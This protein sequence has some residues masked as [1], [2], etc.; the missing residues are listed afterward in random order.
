M[1]NINQA[2]PSG[3]WQVC[4]EGGTEMQTGVVDTLEISVENLQKAKIQSSK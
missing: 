1:A 4:G 3:R 2:S